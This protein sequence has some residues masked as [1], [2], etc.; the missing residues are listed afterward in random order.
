MKKLLLI[1]VAAVAIVACKK[2]KNEPVAPN[3]GNG[4]N[5]GGGTQTEQ[6]TPV[7][8][9]FVKQIIKTSLTG[10]VATTTYNVQNNV[11]KSWVEQNSQNTVTHTLEYNGKN[12]KTYRL[13]DSSRGLDELYSFVYENNKLTK[14]TYKTGSSQPDTF[15]IT[16][17]DK[18]RITK[19]ENPGVGNHFNVMPSVI[20]FDYGTTTLTVKNYDGNATTTYAYGYKDDNVVAVNYNGATQ[21]Y[22]YDTTVVNDLS[23]PYILLADLAKVNVRGHDGDISFVAEENIF[24]NQSKNVCKK[25]L[26]FDRVITK[27]GNKPL[28]IVKQPTGEKIIYKY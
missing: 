26:F 6:P 24:A 20:T 19:K 11:L 4:N 9:G 18:G 7:P 28:E 17:D 12:L 3:G 2:D 27:N 21:T 5:G 16:T 14:I 13:Q 22:E 15:I 1:A 23:N 10:A 8:A 25:Y